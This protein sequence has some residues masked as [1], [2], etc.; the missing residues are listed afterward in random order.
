M[1][2]IFALSTPLEQTF[3][4]SEL[5][6]DEYLETSTQKVDK[7]DLHQ[8]VQLMMSESKLEVSQ[9]SRYDN[10]MSLLEQEEQQS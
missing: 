6:R 1:D 10:L 9:V 5:R 4:P 3:K 8:D 2:Q 7:L